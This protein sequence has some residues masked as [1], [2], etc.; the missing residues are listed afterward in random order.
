MRHAPIDPALFVENSPAG[1]LLEP[2][3]L[4]V[5][6]SNDVLP[7]NADGTLP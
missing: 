2:K 5:V 7:S 6:N 3:S 1:G 4:A